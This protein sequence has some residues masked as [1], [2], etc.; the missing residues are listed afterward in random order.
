MLKTPRAFL[1]S[2]RPY[3]P[4]EWGDPN[5]DEMRN[6]TKKGEFNLTCEIGCK[7]LFR[8][9]GETR[10]SHFA[11]YP[12]SKCDFIDKYSSSPG[13]VETESF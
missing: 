1:D 10:R 6:R 3:T 7:V 11:H 12:D 13:G 9:G 2:K 8:H 4:E 5:N